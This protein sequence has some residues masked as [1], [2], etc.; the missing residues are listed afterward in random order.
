MAK[1]CLFSERTLKYW[2]AGYRKYEIDG[3]EN[4]S[5]KLK[6]NPKETSI[7]IKEKVVEIRK[8]TRLC[9]KKLKWKLEKESIGRNGNHLN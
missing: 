5:R 6:T 2:L 7:R 8:E 3:L 9:G 1:V 4:K